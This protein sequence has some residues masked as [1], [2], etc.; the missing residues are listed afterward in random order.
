MTAKDFRTWHGTAR[1]AADLAATGPKPTET[2]RKKAVAAAMREVADLLGNT[3]ATARSAYVD[4]RVV[5]KYQ[6]GEV[7]DGDDEKAVLDLLVDD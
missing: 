5:E 4:P 6:R 3:P 2:A 1:A 7:A